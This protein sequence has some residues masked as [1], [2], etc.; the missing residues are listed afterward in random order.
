[1]CYAPKNKDKYDK[2]KAK[3][4]RLNTRAAVVLTH[5][6]PAQGEQLKAE[7][8]AL[9]VWTFNKKSRPA[10]PPRSCYRRQPAHRRRT[11]I[12][13]TCSAA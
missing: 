9:D 4:E 2:R 13:P 5:E 10:L 11:N 1:M 6:G 8:K 3:V 7:Y 12:A